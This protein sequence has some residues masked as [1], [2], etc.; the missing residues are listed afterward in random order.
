MRLITIQM[1]LN[2]KILGLSGEKENIKINVEHFMELSF[3]LSF[4][5]DDELQYEVFKALKDIVVVFRS[6]KYGWSVEML[7]RDEIRLCM[8]WLVS[9]TAA[10]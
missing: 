5:F 10:V 3:A 1:G 6:L 9:R 7:N 2:C 8:H 4:N